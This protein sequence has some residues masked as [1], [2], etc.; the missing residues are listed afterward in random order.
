MFGS[1]TKHK[2]TRTKTRTLPSAV[3][4]RPGLRGWRGGGQGEAAYVTA[5]D[6][7]RG[8][9]VQVCGLWPFVGGSGTDSWCTDWG[10]Y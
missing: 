7:W 10:S 2:R 9:S 1:K 3:V 8:T 6:E 4:R 5:A